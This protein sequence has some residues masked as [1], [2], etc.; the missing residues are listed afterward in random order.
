MMCE[1]IFSSYYLIWQSESIIDSLAISCNTDALKHTETGAGPFVPSIRK[2][3]SIQSVLS[4]HIH[5]K[6]L[7]PSHWRIFASTVH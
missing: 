3:F 4:L 5:C 2:S 1:V 7:D 6:K